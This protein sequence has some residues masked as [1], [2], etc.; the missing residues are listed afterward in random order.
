MQQTALHVLILCTSL[1]LNIPAHSWNRDGVSCC[2]RMSRIMA[3]IEGWAAIPR[4]RKR[5]IK[6]TR[7]E[8]MWHH[9]AVNA[10]HFKFHASA[11]GRVMPS[12]AGTERNGAT[13]GLPNLAGVTQAHTVLLMPGACMGLRPQSK[14]ISWLQ[15]IQQRQRPDK[16]NPAVRCCDCH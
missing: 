2:F 16:V 5:Q 6:S 14:E 4:H 12:T 9:V 3:K 13:S 11:Q 10:R 7:R 1:Y 15:Q 8:Q